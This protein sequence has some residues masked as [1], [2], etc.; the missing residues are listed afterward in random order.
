VI[1]DEVCVEAFMATRFG[2]DGSDVAP[3]GTGVWSKALWF[4]RAGRDYV[5]CVP[6]ALSQARGVT[7]RALTS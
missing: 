6:F 5:I 2:S 7:V 3:L 1:V 4:R